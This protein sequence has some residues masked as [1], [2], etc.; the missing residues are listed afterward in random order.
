MEGSKAAAYAKIIEAVFFRRFR[1]GDRSVDF[2]RSDLIE[3]ASTLGIARPSNVGDVVYT[4]RFRKPLPQSIARRAPVGHSWII[5]LIGT[6]KYQFYATTHPFIVPREHLAA[7]KVPDATPGV[8]ARYAMT[9]E[10][11]LLAKLRY[12]RLLDIFTG[13]TC[14][15]LQ[16]HLRTQVPDIGQTETDELYVGVDKRGAHYIF[17]VQAKGGRDRLSIVQIEQDLAVCQ[18]KFPGR[19]CR[20]VAAQFVGSNLIALFLFEQNADG[21]AQIAEERH[22]RLVPA[23]EI[24][25]AEL[26]AY[27]EVT[28]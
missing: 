19:I 20:P 24:S 6:A 22:Y 18:A 9:D 12:N 21:A 3:A 14:Y 15:S 23:D 26:R 27:G 10:Q 2:Q 17:P 13:V 25:A 1:E 11:A 28:A 4:F 5:R 7:I 16:S 8:I